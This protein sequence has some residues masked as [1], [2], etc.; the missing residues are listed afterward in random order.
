[1]LGQVR[2]VPGVTHASV[3]AGSAFGF[4]FG[5][6]IYRPATPPATGTPMPNFRAV[7]DDYFPTL[8]TN[9]VRGRLFNRG[10]H[11]QNS[12]VA[13]VDEATAKEF[14]SGGDVLE[15]CVVVGDDPCVHIVGVVKDAVLWDMLGKK[16]TL[17][18][19]PIESWTMGPIT[20]EIRTAGDPVSLVPA[21]RRALQSVSPDL[22]WVDVHPV[23][24]DLDPQL[25]PRRVSASMFTAFG[26]V[27]LG[28]AAVGLY[29]LLA[30]AVA[31]RSHEIG[32]RKALGADDSGI[33][34][35]VLRGALGVAVVGV[36]V[37]LAASLAASKLVAS[38]LYGV[39]PRDP[40]IMSISA[41]SL[42]VVTIIAAL[43][44]V[45]RATRV[46]PVVTLRAD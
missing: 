42:I 22:P 27:A 39:S 24:Q 30:Y 15:G 6:A 7:G 12:H 18:Y 44:P 4:G 28:L 34:G 2:R 29:G 11:R 35:M 3:S 16:G 10:D 33:A 45:R 43:A 20:M 23:K 14:F 36:V 37:G 17:V 8:G 32:V 40:V 9:L 5:I 21:I 38:Q 46:D 13:I 31:Q 26:F 1:M 19:A 25:R 41:A